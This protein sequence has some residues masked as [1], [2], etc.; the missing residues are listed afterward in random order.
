MSTWLGEGLK[1]LQGKSGRQS[2]MYQSS[3]K[4]SSFA[5]LGRRGQSTPSGDTTSLGWL[6]SAACVWVPWIVVLADVNHWS[7]TD[8]VR[9]PDPSPDETGA[10]RSAQK[11]SLGKA[12]FPGLAFRDDRDRSKQDSLSMHD[13]LELDS[14]LLGGWKRSRARTTMI[15]SLSTFT[16]PIVHGI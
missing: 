11:S 14:G 8:I 9:V 12:S 6:L 1:P 4:L 7:G 10:S 5:G 15:L 16:E 3:V 13:C 2:G